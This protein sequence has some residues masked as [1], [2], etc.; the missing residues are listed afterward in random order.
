MKIWALLKTQ[1]N[2]ICNDILL[3]K[4]GYCVHDS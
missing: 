3:S 2:F 4:T 1:K